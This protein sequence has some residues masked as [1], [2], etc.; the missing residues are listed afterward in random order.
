MT[1]L[2]SGED[3]VNPEVCVCVAR[4][5]CV[6]LVSGGPR[7]PRESLLQVGLGKLSLTSHSYFT[8]EP[9]HFLEILSFQSSLW[10]WEDWGKRGSDRYLRITVAPGL[11]VSR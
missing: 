4:S 1:L 7:L 2:V 5:W 11:R 6:V 10:Q 3:R 9:V 8:F